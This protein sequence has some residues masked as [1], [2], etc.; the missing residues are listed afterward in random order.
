MTQCLRRTDLVLLR[1]FTVT[2]AG[3]G[4]GIKDFFDSSGGRQQLRNLPRVYIAG[5]AAAGA[6]LSR[7][8]RGADGRHSAVGRIAKEQQSLRVIDDVVAIIRAREKQVT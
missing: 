6:I 7:Q 4:K 5:A 3:R 1:R 8:D 2:A